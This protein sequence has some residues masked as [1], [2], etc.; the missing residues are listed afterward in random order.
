[1]PDRFVWKWTTDGAYSASSAYRSFFIG[2]S[3]L[4]GVKHL[5]HANAPPK[6]RFFFWVTLHGRLWTAERR[7]HHG[8]QQSASCVLCA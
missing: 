3:M 5:W 7:T 8:L 4:V 2:R 1:V 6:V